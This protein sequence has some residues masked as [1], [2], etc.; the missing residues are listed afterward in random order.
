MHENTWTPLYQNP[1]VIIGVHIYLPS[2]QWAQ[3]I[4]FMQWDSQSPV[5]MGTLL[6]HHSVV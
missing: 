4:R 5:S 1:R 2:A 3:V 6:L